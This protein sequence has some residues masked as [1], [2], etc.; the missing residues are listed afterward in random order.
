M[1]RIISGEAKGRKIQVPQEAETRPTTDRVREA[2]FNSLYQLAEPPIP[3]DCK[4]L[5]LFAGS[6]ALGIEALSRGASSATFIDHD[7]D[8]IKTVHSNLSQL[9]FRQRAEIIRFDALEYLKTPDLTYDLVFLDPPFAFE[10][11]SDLLK[12]MENYKILVIGSNREIEVSDET[13]EVIK[14]D[15]YSSTYIKVCVNRKK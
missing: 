13:W 10:A 3:Q 15:K 8:A 11:W 7:K 1:I 6:G 4:V 5:D 12:F 14:Q 9:D 2:I